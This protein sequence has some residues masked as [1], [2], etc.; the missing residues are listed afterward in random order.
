MAIAS[1]LLGFALL[2]T[3]AALAYRP[4]GFLLAGSGFLYAGILAAKK[5]TK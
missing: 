1:V 4:L 3:G 5:A 2:I